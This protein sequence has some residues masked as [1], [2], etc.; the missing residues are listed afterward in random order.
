MHGKIDAKLHSPKPLQIGTVLHKVIMLSDYK[1][2]D[3]L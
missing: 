3:M 2:S 1:Y